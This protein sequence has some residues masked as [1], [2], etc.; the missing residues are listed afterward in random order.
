MFELI[1]LSFREW[2]AEGCFEIMRPDLRCWH[3]SPDAS[4][5]LVLA[6]L[7]CVTRVNRESPS[8]KTQSIVIAFLSLPYRLHRSSRINTRSSAEVYFS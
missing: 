4:P 8:L 3:R 7:R 5:N 2:N 6:T 1:V